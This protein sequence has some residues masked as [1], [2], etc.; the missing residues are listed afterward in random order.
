MNKMKIEVG[1][2]VIESNGRCFEIYKPVQPGKDAK[3][4][5]YKKTN[6]QYYVT[7]EAMLKSLP[8]RMVMTESEA[9]TL[10]ELLRDTK[11]HHQLIAESV[12]LST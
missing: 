12:R 1:N 10:A 7:M 5:D 8:V 2:Y 3:S 11:N 9:T 6:Q 4:Q